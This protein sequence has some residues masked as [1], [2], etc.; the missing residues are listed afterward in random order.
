MNARKIHH[1]IHPVSR[2]VTIADTTEWIKYNNAPLGPLHKAARIYA[3]AYAS[4][5][6][7][8]NASVFSPKYITARALNISKMSTRHLIAKFVNLRNSMNK[9]KIVSWKKFHKRNK[10]QY[11]HSLLILKYFIFYVQ[12]LYWITKCIAKEIHSWG[13]KP[14]LAFNGRTWNA[15]KIACNCVKRSNS[16]NSCNFWM[17]STV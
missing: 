11:W 13:H 12:F 14:F 7:E 16:R 6:Q 9:Y 5:E 2:F 15:Q 4:R 17:H 10:M 3:F 1:L 8:Q